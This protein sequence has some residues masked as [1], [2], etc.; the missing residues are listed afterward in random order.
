MQI[1]L[2]ILAP[3]MKPVRNRKTGKVTMTLL[4]T[5]IHFNHDPSERFFK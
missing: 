2:T 4:P 5:E 3:T 1:E